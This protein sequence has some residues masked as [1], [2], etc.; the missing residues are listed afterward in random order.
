MISTNTILTQPPTLLYGTTSNSS[1]WHNL[2]HFIMAQPS[3][4]H[5]GTTSNEQYRNFAAILPPSI[6]DSCSIATSYTLAF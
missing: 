2:Q 3:T 4:P 6:F 5:Y 1:L